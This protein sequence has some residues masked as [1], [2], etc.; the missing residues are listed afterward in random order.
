[1]I[2]T[3]KYYCFL[4]ICI[5]CNDQNKIQDA[6]LQKYNERKEEFIKTNI[7]ECAR[8]YLELAELTAD[9][10]LIRESK[11]S[12]YDS[13]TIPVDTFKPSNPNIQFPEYQKPTK[14]I[15]QIDKSKK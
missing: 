1:M 4:F 6:A 2:N 10:I 13:L 11:A 9:S 5:A 3:L 8:K 14:P 7:T 15:D 12:K